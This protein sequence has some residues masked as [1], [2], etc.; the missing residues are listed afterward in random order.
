MQGATPESKTGWAALFVIWRAYTTGSTWA[1]WLVGIL[2]LWAHS[3][4]FQLRLEARTG[5]MQGSNASGINLLLTIGI[6]LLVLY[7]LFTWLF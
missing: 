5:N 7:F 3:S 4:D 6:F 1:L 2:A